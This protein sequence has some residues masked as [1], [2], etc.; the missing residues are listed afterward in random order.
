MSYEVP[1]AQD[2][3]NSGGDFV[4][5]K[6][7]E[8]IVKVAKIWL[9][10]GPTF[11]NRVPDYQNKV[12][13]YR[14]ICLPYAL[15]SGAPMRDINGEEITPLS[16]WMFK[17][18]NPLSIGSHA[19]YGPSTMRQ[20]GAYLQGIENAEPPFSV[21][22]FI[23]IDVNHNPVKDADMR[24][25]FL[26]NPAAMR[27]KGYND[28]WDIRSLAGKFIGCSIALEEKKGKK[29]NSITRFALLPENFVVPTDESQSEAMTKFEEKFV[30][31][32]AKDKERNADRSNSAPSQQSYS[33][34]ST[35]AASAPASTPTP[36]TDDVEVA[37]D[38]LDTE[39]IPF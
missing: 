7:E 8:Y 11:V 16:R 32:L 12:V 36:T 4:P 15:R 14:T 26:N 5:L 21:P 1:S 9:D 18:F 38:M 34:P 33:Q 25:A 24:A 3:G 22:D 28:V 37:E 13:R 35:P 39:D 20:M 27:A 30:T 17:D 23:L 31:F 10:K 19:S 6:Q 2:A 29:V